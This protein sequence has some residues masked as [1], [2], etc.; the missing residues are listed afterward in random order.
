MEHGNAKLRLPTSA[1][2]DAGV[3]IIP[4]MTSPIFSSV[5]LVTILAC[6]LALLV[7]K[8]GGKLFWYDELL[9]FHISR[10]R[11]FSL[12]WRAL[13][14]GVDGSP[15]GYYVMVRLAGMLPGDPHI[16]LRLPSIVGYLLTLLSV[17]WF[18]RRR[19][20]ATAGLAAV[21]L[22]TLS[23]FR[24]Y[25]VEA[26]PYSL[27]VGFLGISAV[28]WQK[29]DENRF[30]TPLFALFLTLAVSSH[31]L[32]VVAVSCFGTAEL[33]RTLL[34][35]QMRWGVW[36]G[37]LFASCPFLM[38]LPVLLSY[39]E[40]YGGN[41]WEQSSWFTAVSTYRYYLGLDWK[42]VF[43]LILYFGLVVGDSLL[44]MM[45]HSREGSCE[46]AFNPAEITL[47]SGLLLY[48]ALLVVLTKLCGSGYTSRYGWPGILGLVLGSVY[49][50]RTLWLKS[51]S[52]YLLVALLMVV[53]VQ[54]VSDFQML[55]KAGSTRVD[56]LWTRLEEFG[57]GEPNIP[58]VMGSPLDYLQATEY[59]PSELHA[60]LVSV[61]DDG[62]AKRI[63][64]TDN[65]DKNIRLLAQ[66]LPL[67]VEELSA[68]QSAYRSFILYS[69]GDF[70]WITQYLLENRYR[71]LLLA[72]DARHSLYIAER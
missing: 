71:L 43:V 62:E 16:T 46:R 64:G 52:A 53:A 28:L 38:T 18:A 8:A 49:L 13:Q 58:V 21:L 24:E 39:R 37:C 27:L 12:L 19:M 20:P 11:P 47:I 51:S 1:P 22:I 66:F 48:P 61:V 23:P 72:K 2:D 44:R 32:A 69:G 36:A 50:L 68:F 14:T 3:A 26:R 55:A 45:R 34:S 63:A 31:Y 67:H 59:A 6:E 29:I 60:Q 17:Y 41:F 42:L 10:L 35:R 7:F 54:G 15:V 33:A 9:T 65:V 70:D 40:I 5:L 25:A 30:V 57:H 4:A 56:K